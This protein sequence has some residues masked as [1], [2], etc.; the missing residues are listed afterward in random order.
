[1]GKTQKLKKSE[2]HRIF[3]QSLVGCEYICSDYDAVPL[4]LD[5]VSPFKVK[6]RVYIFNSTNPVG[7]RASD[8]YKIQPIV[9][10]QA[11]G[12]CGSFDFS[13]NRIVLLVGYAQLN[14]D[15]IF[16]LWDPLHHSNFKYSSNIQ[17]KSVAVIEAFSKEVS[18]AEKKNGELVIASRPEYL[19]KAIQKRITTV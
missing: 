4:L 2:L 16:I 19:W 10:G 9:P 6:L 17:V 8:E 3:T 1:M 15:G 7:G 11:R 12:E 5:I 18:I 13:D 14:D